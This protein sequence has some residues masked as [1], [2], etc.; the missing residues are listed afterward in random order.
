MAP[1]IPCTV[2]ECQFATPANLSGEIAFQLLQNHRQD[3]HGRQHPDTPPA[4]PAFKTERP[5]RPSVTAGMSETDWNFFLHE[6]NRYT[7]QTSISGATLRDELW[8]CMETDLRQLAFSEGS[9]ATTEEELLKKIKDLAVTVLHS[10]VHVVNLHKMTQAE[11][12]TA[13]AFAARVRGTANNC[14]LAKACPKAD[15]TQRVSYVE[16]T[17]F[18]VVMAGLRDEE[19]REK[20]LTQAMLG[21]VVDLNTLI[22]YVTAEESARAKVG[23]HDLC[24]IRRLKPDSP[25]PPP[26]GGGSPI[27]RL[28]TCGCCGQPQHGE[29]N[30]DRIQKCRAYGHQCSKCNKM[31]H[32]PSLCR[33]HGRAAAITSS[34]KQRGEPNTVTTGGMTTFM[35]TMMATAKVT[36][37]ASAKPF[38]QAIKTNTMASVTTLPMPHYIYSKTE[39]AWK[40]QKPRGAPVLTVSLS[41]DRA[42]YGELKLCPP[43]LVKRAGSGH[44]RARRAT[45]DTGAQLVV[46][47]IS[48]LHT[49]GIKSNSIF[50]VATAL[51]TVTKAPVDLVGGLF[52]VITASNSVSGETR[53]TRQLCYV[54]KTV[55]GIYLSDEA[56][57]D[58]GCVPQDFPSVGS[59]DPPNTKTNI[60]VVGASDK[61]HAVNLHSQ[62][63]N[64]PFHPRE[65]DNGVS[66]TSGGGEAGGSPGLRKCV[67]TG[68]VG[69]HDIPC[70]CPRRSLPPTDNPVLPCEPTTENLHI[71]KQYILDRF[72]SSGFNTCEHQALPLMSDAP[73]L[74]LFA[75]KH[76]TPVAISSPGAVPHHWMADV[77][78]GLDRDERLGV[79]ERLPVNQPVKW[80]ARMLITPKHDGSPRRVIDYGQLNKNCPRQT[81]HTKSPWNIASSIPGGKIK[82]V[83]DNWHGYHSVPIHPADREYT[84]FLTPWGRYQYRTTPQGLLCA[85]D[86][87]TQRMDL[88]VGDMQDYEHCVD[89]SIL[90]DNDIET[91]F[92]RVC[93]FIKKCS[94]AG[95]VFN[96]AKF[97]FGQTKVDFLGFQLTE[98][99]VQPHPDMI[100]NI[101]EFPRPQSITDVRAWFGLVNQISYSF[102]TT[103]AMAPFR[104]LLSSKLPF[105]WSAELETAFEDSKEEIARQCA[106]GVRNFKLNAPTA[107]ATDWSKLAMGCWLT[108]KYCECEGP[109]SP[110]CCKTGWQTVMVASKFCS[111]AESR[112][113]PIE[114]EACATAW[115]LDKCR[116]FVLGHPQLLLAVDHK[117][118]LAIL[119]PDQDLSALLNPRLLN[120][121]MKT[122]A[123]TFTPMHIPGK[124]NVV[125]DSLSRRRD[126]PI[127]SM[128]TMTAPPP[129]VNNVLPQ[130]ADTSGPPDWV[131]PPTVAAMISQL[132]AQTHHP[133]SDCHFTMNNEVLEEQMTGL[134]QSCLAALTPKAAADIALYGDHQV[135]VIT[136]D[137][138]VETCKQSSTYQLLHKTVSQGVPE[139]SQDWDNKIQPYFKSRHGLSTLGP[140]VMLYDRPVIPALLRQEVMEH[141]HAA[142]GC[143]SGMFQRASNTVYWPGYR[144]DINAFQASC[145]TCRRI[146][147]S[148]PC[149]PPSTPLEVPNSPFESICAD[150]FSYAAKNYLIIVDRYTNWLAIFRLA[151]DDTSHLIQALREYFCYFGVCSTLSTDG[152]SV[153]TSTEM[154]EFRSRWGFKHRI[155]SAYFPRSNKRAE[156]GVK[157]AK[158]LIQDNLNPNGDLNTDKFARALMIHRNTPD[159]TT[160]I[161]PAQLVYGR[162]LKDH[163]PVPPTAQFQPRKEWQDLAARRE[164]SAMKR[165]YSK[166]ED[167]TRGSKHLQPLIVGDR[168]YIQDQTGKTP[169][170]W[171]KSGLILE[172]QSHDSYLVKV[173]GSGKVTKRNRQ[174]LRK[175]QPFFTDVAQPVTTP[176]IPPVA[177][178][179]HP[180]Q[181]PATPVLPVPLSTQA[182][183]KTP[184]HPREVDNGVSRTSGG[185]GGGGRPRPH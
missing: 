180:V 15:C 73:P 149:M 107:L 16:E 133:T 144:Q 42:A 28:K 6:W 53:K 11:G 58:L 80:C 62:P 19:L 65:A 151:K 10:S 130:Y 68:V 139:D 63:T 70:S 13:K 82:S 39:G 79:I 77:K 52:L 150:F 118:L 113:H 54:S 3:V 109:P 115:A 131:S 24:G 91:N 47:N 34:P 44:A 40:Q 12:E 51:N 48:E 41:L 164:E 78:A 67:N 97:Q 134:V 136:W 153:F 173:D 27:Q 141:L 132:A 152:A 55:P 177:H 178:L 25:R 110:L 168:V 142:H 120:F 101:R 111:P 22:T 45:T 185:G 108:Q 64:P 93:E 5:A 102:S 8:S 81:H 14:T 96:P 2:P 169:R 146:A 184:S 145:N 59:C 29:N 172:N 154:A 174:F 166:V 117:P 175:Y 37:P 36:S 99:G 17:C 88:I 60:A 105:Y 23:V 87:Y 69:A 71:L 125:P 121:K 31:N 72:S 32:Y 90:W 103:T 26:T 89:D 85:G 18:H 159:P 84:V 183:P 1:A 143:A 66:R 76:A 4:Q 126:S 138:L 171:N 147:P 46:I 75:D 56:C 148:N 92:F 98:T 35:S 94:L 104:H 158:R 155:S 43:K 137:R 116:M 122:M 179:T 123:F 61:D 112:Y 162:Q 30:K 100:S 176:P 20:V 106:V 160:N 124:A 140:V 181:H 7:R 9:T 74:R 156:V 135:S 161:S 167:L 114:G 49:M 50:P 33:S 170:K 129:Q 119:G 38:I 83:L 182:D 21:N 127:S 95:C 157:S 86:G 128:P 163:I 57:E 165:H